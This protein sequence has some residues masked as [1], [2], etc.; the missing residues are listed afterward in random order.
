M[1][2]RPSEASSV[3][4]VKTTCPYCGTGCGVSAEVRSTPGQDNIIAISGDNQHPTNAGKLCS[5]GSHL[6]ETLEPSARLLAPE[7]DGQTTDWKQAL[8]SAA[9]RLQ[10]II[11]Q[12]GPDAV[13]FYCSGQLLTEDYYVANK[14]I[15]GFIGTANID[16][17]SRLCMSSAVVGHKR[18]F[19][20]DSVPACYEDLDLA[21]MVVLTGSNAAWC[22][23]ILFQRI[24][25]AKA[26]NP[27]RRL[28]VID[29]RRTASCDEA[30]LHLPLKPGTDAI[31]FNGLLVWLVARN[32]H[33]ADYI[34]Q[35]TDQF[36]AAIDAARASAPTIEHVANACEL[37]PDAV[38]QFYRWFAE[39]PKTLTCFSQ[40]INQSSSGSDKV[41]AI[42]NVHLATGRIGL[43]GASPFS[44]TGQPNAMGGR[45]VG[46]L[47]NQLAAHMDLQNPAHHQLLS[48][49][50]DSDRVADKPGLKAV[51]LFD[52]VA[53]GQVK[54]VWIMATNPVDSLPDADRVR[55]AL[56]HCEL[57]IVSDCMAATDTAATAN[58]R[59]P[60]AAWGERDGTVTNAERCISRQRALQ[61]LS[62]QARPD[63]WIICQMAQRLGFG[64]AFDFQHPAQIFRE[65]ARLSGYQNSPDALPRGFNISALAEIGDL[66]YENLTPTQWPV[67]TTTKTDQPDTVPSQAVQQAWSG[68][69]RRFANGS[70]DTSSG[71]ANFVAISPRPPAYQTDQQFPLVLNTGRLRDQWHTMTRTGLSPSLSG[72]RPEP[73]VEIHPRDAQR[74]ALKPDGIARLRTRWGTMLARVAVS[75]GQQPGQIFVPMHWSDQFANEGRVCALVNPATDPLSGQPESKH[76][77]VNIEPLASQWYGV[78]IRRDA[79]GSTPLPV[80]Y[81]VRIRE[82]HGHRELLAS[83]TAVQD[84]PAQAAAWLADGNE[85]DTDQWLSYDDHAAGLYRAARLR[86]GELQ[87][88]LYISPAPITFDTAWL[89]ALL[90]PQALS[91]ESRRALLSGQPPQ[92]QTSCGATVCACFGVGRNT[93]VDAINEHS[94]DSAQA[95]GAML[96]AGTNCGSCVPDIRALIEEAALPA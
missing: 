43:P 63:W 8:A 87:A 79:L 22:H 14:L 88:V 35:H 46:G 90:E 30:D 70:F 5:K 86:R 59:F 74:F 93:I 24:R 71:R 40:G 57:V 19:G 50:W 67:I 7:V 78:L 80:D 42:I 27:S 69:A 12:H 89:S 96:K 64:E 54:A 36:D 29:P 84:W 49:F 81:R 45:E 4:C 21:E 77:P 13:A 41:N 3:H 60:A 32:A 47:A 56:E 28:V 26:A 44:L 11:D 82:H 33:H 58:I 76:T 83:T 6:A 20:S 37:A 68:T 31:L 2:D 55:S 73:Q 23:P 18:A 94:L 92:G 95:V 91:L 85:Q 53:Q 15:K 72:H 1:H 38:E 62:G 17:N 16:T 34:A 75:E 9:D 39:T 61:P 65:H 66:A 25:A 10:A 48:R 52:A 51:E